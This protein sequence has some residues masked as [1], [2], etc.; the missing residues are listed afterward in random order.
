MKVE[1]KETSFGSSHGA[2]P[3]NL[4]ELD[5]VDNLARQN[6]RAGLGKVWLQ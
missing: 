4:E 1:M 3:C 6:S 2:S 5:Y